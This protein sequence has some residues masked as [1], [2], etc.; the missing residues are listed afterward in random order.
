[1]LARRLQI[2]DDV[3]DELEWVSA[4]MR[5]RAEVSQAQLSTPELV[6]VTVLDA[7]VHQL[8]GMWRE[9]KAAKHVLAWS[10]VDVRCALAVGC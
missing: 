4:L 7:T 2:P 10:M 8:R 5:A 3:R 9:A 6:D 1:M